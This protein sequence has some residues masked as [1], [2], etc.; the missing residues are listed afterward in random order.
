[1]KFRRFL[2][3]VPKPVRTAA[4]IFVGCAMLIGL[5]AGLVL[6]NA[7]GRISAGG[8]G[9]LAGIGFGVAIAVWVLCLG[10]VYG[11]ARRRAMPPIAWTLVAILVPN[12]LGF[13]LYFVMRRPV[14]V[15]CAYCGQAMASDQRFCSGCGT[16]Q[17]RLPSGDVRPPLG[18]S[19]MGSSGM[20]SSGGLGSMPTV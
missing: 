9:F 3:V 20:G 16:S 11:D 13:L 12:L 14:T 15:P 19:G 5:V 17:S 8:I 4:P 18:S 6:G 7:D 2:D 1:M 10:Y